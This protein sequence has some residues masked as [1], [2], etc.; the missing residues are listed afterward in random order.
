MIRRHNDVGRQLQQL[1][2]MNWP[3]TVLEPVIRHGNPSLPEGHAERN[4]LVGDLLVRGGVHT[5]HTDAIIDIQVI[6]LN[7]PSRRTTRKRGKP[8]EGQKGGQKQAPAREAPD[9]EIEGDDEEG[10][11]A[12][13]GKGRLEK[14]DAPAQE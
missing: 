9:S 2:E 5:P 12:L 8:K 10:V 14:E 11:E 1:A 6:Y 13:E 7:A 4:G 3:G